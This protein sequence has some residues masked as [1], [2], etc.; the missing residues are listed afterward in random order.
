MIVG[1]LLQHRTNELVLGSGFIKINVLIKEKLYKESF[2]RGYFSAAYFETP[3]DVI[4]DPGLIVSALYPNIKLGK[5]RSKIGFIPHVAE[6]KDFI[7]NK[8]IIPDYI[9]LIM[10]IEHPKQVL[11]EIS[12]CSSIYS[13]S[14]HGLIFAHSIGVNA[15]HIIVSDNVIGGDFKFLDYYSVFSTLK[16]D[17]IEFENCDFEELK[18]L[19]VDQL[20]EILSKQDKLVEKLFGQDKE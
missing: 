3:V 13:S 8:Y 7:G 16:Y 15:R 2:L 4:A 1:S 11:K 20:K 10:P 5:F 12:K 17:P 19:S 6:L 18:P 14:L 9:K